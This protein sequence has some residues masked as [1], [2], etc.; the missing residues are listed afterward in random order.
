[1]A[2]LGTLNWQLEP[3]AKWLYALGKYYDERLVVTSA[4]RSIADQQR[5]YCKWVTGQSQFPA[6][7]PGR[8][9]H[10]FGLAWDMARLGVPPKG[11]PLLAYLRQVWE[12]IGGT[13]GGE[14]DPVH[15]SV[16]R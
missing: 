6:A 12:Y 16:R 9:M 3:Y 8:S 11:D 14:V 2:D 10:N 4:Y 15:F 13:T 1:M 7:Q 5:L